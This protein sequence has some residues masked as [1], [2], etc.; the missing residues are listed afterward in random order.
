MKCLIARE[1]VNTTLL[2]VLSPVVAGIRQVCLAD[3]ICEK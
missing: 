3:D 2:E 1:E